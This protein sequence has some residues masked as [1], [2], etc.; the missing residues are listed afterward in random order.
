VRHED[1]EVV[2]LLRRA[3]ELGSFSRAGKATGASRVALGL[4]V[5]RVEEALG[6]RLL[7]RS[8]RKLRLT[9]AGQVFLQRMGRVAE[10]LELAR[11]AVKGEPVPERAASAPTVAALASGPAA[12]AGP[13]PTAA[14][15]G[16]SLGPGRLDLV[17][18]QLPDGQWVAIGFPGERVAVGQTVEEA[19]A[20]L[21]QGLAS[22]RG[23]ER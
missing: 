5:S 21:A 18:R 2:H 13:A 15:A 22:G 12:A 6:V 11:R 17:L 7:E 9:H 8:T 23:G 4:K 14:A 3:V 20:R 19:L 1:L 10:E 16:A